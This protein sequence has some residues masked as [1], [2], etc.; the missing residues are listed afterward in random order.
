MQTETNT[1]ASKEKCLPAQTV[2]NSFIN[3]VVG[4]SEIEAAFHAPVVVTSRGK[5]LDGKQMTGKL[6][7]S[8]CRGCG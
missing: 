4:E 3:I 8:L 6:T 2:Y 7:I 5:N 1:S